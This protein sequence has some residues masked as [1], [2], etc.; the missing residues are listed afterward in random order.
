MFGIAM[1]I[2]SQ[3]S[4]V[5]NKE[6]MCHLLH[7]PALCPSPA[8]LARLLEL[9]QHHKRQNW[10]WVSH[11]G[12]V[13]KQQFLIALHSD[14]PQTARV[15]RPLLHIDFSPSVVTGTILVDED[16]FFG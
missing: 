6:L 9:E 4:P 11:V 13:I 12:P 10:H 5:L 14:D 15:S 7:H 1:C 8:M 16:S 2:L 3:A